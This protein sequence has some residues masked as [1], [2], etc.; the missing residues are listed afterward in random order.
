MSAVHDQY[1]RFLAWL[2]GRGFPEDAIRVAKIVSANLDRVVPT[3]S[4]RGQRA[5]VLTPILR[6]LLPE[7][8][9]T[10]EGQADQVPA[11][12]SWARLRLLSVGPFRG[13]RYEHR[14]DLDKRVVLFQGPNG[15]G[16]TSVCEAMEYALLG[17]IE[18]AAAKRIDPLEDYFRNVHARRYAT[19]QLWAQGAADDAPL[20]ANPDLLR[21]ALIEKNRIEDFARIASHRPSEAEA[22]IATLF[23]LDAFS[24]FVK[25]FTA[26]LDSNLSLLAIKA[27]LLAARREATAHSETEVAEEENAL[28]ERA[29]EE[30]ELAADAGMG[31]PVLLAALGLIGGPGRLQQLIDATD[32]QAR[33]QV[34]LAPSHFY[35][36]RQGL[37]QVDVELTSIEEELRARASEVNFK[38]LFEAVSALKEHSPDQC[39]ACT[40]PL[41]AVAANPFERAE[42]GRAALA[43]LADL[44]ERAD[45]ARVRKEEMLREL[46]RDLAK[47]A[48]FRRSEGGDGQEE[49]WVGAAGRSDEPALGAVDRDFD[50]DK[51]IDV[52]QTAR[53]CLREDRTIAE[54]HQARVAL[55][56]ERNRLSSLSVR[57]TTLVERRRLTIERI[58]A[59]KASI[60]QFEEDNAELI[61]DVPVEAKRIATERR[62]QTAYAAFKTAIDQYTEALPEGLLA[63]LNELTRDIYNS[64]NVRDA[65]CDKLSAVSLPLR[66]GERIQV[67]FRGAPQVAR[68]ALHLLSEG[69]I[70]CL[71]LA[72]LL[73]KNI[74]LGLP[75]VVFDDAVNA[76]DDDHRRGLRETLFENPQLLQKQL[77]ITCHSPEFIKSV[78]QIDGTALHYVLAHHAGDYQ[79]RVLT[80]TTRHFLDL[81]QE[82]L[83]NG[84]P[85][86][87]LAACRQAMENLVYRTWRKIPSEHSQLTVPIRVPDTRG[88]L[89]TVATLVLQ[90]M[91][92]TIA[93]EVLQGDRWTNRRDGLAAIIGVPQHTLT[94]SVLNKGAHEEEDR[95]DFE[96]DLVEGVLAALRQIS[97]SFGA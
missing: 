31:Y 59:A 73:A 11:A 50:K 76:I 58:A 86:Q 6:Q 84:D 80:G 37:N 92:Q 46:A 18:E 26:N 49:G 33:V 30:A 87:C 28:A 89:L 81:A 21:F 29:R 79:P 35:F 34:G 77:I 85:R 4:N 63:N 96:I 38:E 56:E 74:Q 95:E 20:E 48:D 72:I 17:S 2:P 75:I 40:T 44:E 69:H 16:K 13:F 14:F 67:Y 91:N 36:N 71:G 10:L 94:Y 43:E 27:S 7:T 53:R 82:R 83:D 64:V 5:T 1:Q 42:A 41:D 97:Q 24:E 68:D 15:S 61:A 52:L 9:A 39:P 60:W 23:G 51:W 78:L 47:L 12:L 70:R 45:N 25:N 62:I 55:V 19:P 88:E 8:D 66:G 22:L 93:Q 90:R 57:A 32:Q 65:D 54:E 3:V